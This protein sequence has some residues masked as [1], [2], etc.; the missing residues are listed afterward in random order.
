MDE[1]TEGVGTEIFVGSG[2]VDGLDLGIF[3][4]AY[5]RIFYLYLYLFMHNLGKAASWFLFLQIHSCR[6]LLFRFIDWLIHEL[7]D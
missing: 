2:T 5:Q 6:G 3:L 7:I 4:I 1:A